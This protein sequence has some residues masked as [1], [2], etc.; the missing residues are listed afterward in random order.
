MQEEFY[1]QG[2]LERAAGLPV[3][4]LNDR[5]NPDRAVSSQVPQA[6]SSCAWW[7]C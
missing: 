5:T 1:H 3:S 4:P 6:P 2:D 7:Q